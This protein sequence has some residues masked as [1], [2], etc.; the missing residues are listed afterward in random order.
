MDGTHVPHLSYV[1][2]SI[3]GSGCNLGAGT[4][5]GNIRFDRRSIRMHVKDQLV[6]SGRRKL[7]TVLGD[8]VQTGINVSF[9]PGVKVGHGAQI[10]AHVFVNKDVPAK[11]RIYLSQELSYKKLD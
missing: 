9:T 8:N 5:V 3:I 1:G 2:D 10:G 6:D 4:I 11:V 7:G